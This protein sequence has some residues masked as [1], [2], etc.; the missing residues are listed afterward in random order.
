M[1][2]PPRQHLPFRICDWHETV[3]TGQPLSVCR[4]DEVAE[5]A[6]YFAGLKPRNLISVIETNSVPKTYVAWL[7][8]AAPNDGE[9]EP[10]GNRIVEV[11]DNLDEFELY[12]PRAK[13][14]AYVPVGSIA[15]G[16]ALASNGGS[17]KTV[18]CGVC[19]GPDLNGL[20][21]IPGIAGRSPSYI[22]RQLYD[23]KHGDRA[24][25]WSP[26]M[27]KVVSNLDED[28]LVSVA[29]YLASRRP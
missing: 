5:A 10:I 19:H 12:D 3:G 6:A 14:T 4:K 15:K 27:A 24:G 26:L 1:A 16:E 22:V 17:G 13:F 23:M 11:P 29:A 18:P 20:G 28:D 9:K 7:I 2:H 25:P 8:Y 21:P